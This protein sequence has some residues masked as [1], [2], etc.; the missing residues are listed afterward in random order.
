M[1]F[2][3]YPNQIIKLPIDDYNQSLKNFLYLRGSLVLKI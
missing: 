3:H 2:S 1:G